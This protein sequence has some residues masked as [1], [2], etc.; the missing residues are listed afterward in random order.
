[1]HALGDFRMLDSKK[2]YPSGLN[3]TWAISLRRSAQALFADP[4]LTP[5]LGADRPFYQGARGGRDE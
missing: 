5:S 3:A 1:M 2:N 4:K